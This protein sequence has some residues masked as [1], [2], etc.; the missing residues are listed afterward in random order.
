M[1]VFIYQWHTARIKSRQTTSIHCRL[2]KYDAF[3]LLGSHLHSLEMVLNMTNS[4]IIIM[5]SFI[6]YVSLQASCLSHFLDGFDAANATPKPKHQ[7]HFCLEY[8]VL[9]S[10]FQLS[11]VSKIDC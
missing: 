8:C 7:T 10:L 6:R 2:E 3:G 5:H 9:C 11:S 1:K 4:I